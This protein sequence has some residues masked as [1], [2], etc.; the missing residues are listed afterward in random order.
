MSATCHTV[1]LNYFEVVPRKTKE[2]KF[3]E[4]SIKIKLFY[5][6]NLLKIT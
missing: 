4:G 2:T 1:C 6:V 5:E 3:E